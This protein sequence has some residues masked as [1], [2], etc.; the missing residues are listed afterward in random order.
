LFYRFK[1]SKPFFDIREADLK[2]KAPLDNGG[3]GVAGVP[4]K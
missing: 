4:R 2:E 1:V 3:G